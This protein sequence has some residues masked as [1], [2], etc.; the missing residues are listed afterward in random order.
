M[1]CTL[2]SNQNLTLNTI[3]PK[4]F[5]WYFK[6][7]TISRILSATNNFYHNLN[8]ILENEEFFMSIQVEQVE[9]SKSIL[10]SPIQE[11]VSPTCLYFTYFLANMYIS[12][13]LAI[14]VAEP[15]FASLHFVNHLNETW[16]STAVPLPTGNYSI[17]FI[18]IGSAI[19]S[20]G[21]KSVY[22]EPG[23]CDFAGTCIVFRWQCYTKSI[24]K[25]KPCLTH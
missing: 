17:W 19:S 6:V 13:Y 5:R 12:L 20:A 18:T 15:P 16:N 23:D 25:V 22:F 7:I 24:Y 3:T 11:V 4:S 2:Y 8:F 1:Y 21:L 10:V 14:G 9:A